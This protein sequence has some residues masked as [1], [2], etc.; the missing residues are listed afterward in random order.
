MTRTRV[1]RANDLFGRLVATIIGIA[2]ALIPFWLYLLARFTLAPEGFWQ[3]AILLGVGVYF[4]G[5][6]QFL[7]IG[8]CVWFLAIVWG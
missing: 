8:A 1:A 5:F 4:L 2:V 6:I 3:Q 7:L